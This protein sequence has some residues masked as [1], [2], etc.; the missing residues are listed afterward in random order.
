MASAQQ[1]PNGRVP[2]G[3]DSSELQEA[4]RA[5]G[6]IVSAIVLLIAALSIVVPHLIE[7]AAW[8]RLLGLVVGLILVGVGTVVFVQELR[9]QSIIRR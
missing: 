6:M 3:F 4:S 7:V 8:V 2:A 1:S 9:R 5:P